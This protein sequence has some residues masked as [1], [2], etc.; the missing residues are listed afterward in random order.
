MKESILDRLSRKWSGMDF[1]GFFN[2]LYM[3]SDLAER[4][5][6]ELLGDSM[7][8]FTMS[9]DEDSFTFWYGEDRKRVIV[10]SDD[11]IRYGDIRWKYFN[12]PHKME[13]GVIKRR[14]SLG[15]ILNSF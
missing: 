13:S 11:T 14:F 5:Y 8:R 3:N 1:R 4:L 2:V 7:G 6:D 9:I 12:Y 10:I 15:Y